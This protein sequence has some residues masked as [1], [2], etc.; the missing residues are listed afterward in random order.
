MTRPD[1]KK[2]I[3]EYFFT[4]PTARLRVRQLERA[5]GTPLPS[6]TRYVKE[7]EKE[8][9]IKQ[10]TIAGTTTYAADRSS[11]QYLLEKKLHNISEL[12]RSG[13]VEQLIKE[14]SNPAIVLFGSYSKGE[15][16]E[17][18]DIDLYLETPTKKKPAL[19]R[20]EKKLHRSIQLFIHKSIKDIKNKEL[21][22]NIINGTTIN[23]FIE[24]L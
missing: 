7:L 21:A 8:G 13:L 12:H 14:H 5:T 6:V 4:N 20:F 10:T 1:N 19:E 2:T 11:R 3:K 24:A 22:N 23:G 9:I 16:T 15:D 18:S 17:E